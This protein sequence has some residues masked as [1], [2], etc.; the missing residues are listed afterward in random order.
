MNIGSFIRNGLTIHIN[1]DMCEVSGYLGTSFQHYLGKTIPKNKINALFINLS[2]FGFKFHTFYILEIYEII[3]SLLSKREYNLG[4]NVRGLSALLEEIDKHGWG[5]DKIEDREFNYD[6]IPDIF[7][8]KVL[9]HQMYALERYRIIS[10]RIGYRGMLYYV[11]PGG[12]KTMLSLF[13]AELVHSKKI[14]C[15]VPAAVLYKVWVY[16]ITE[17]VYIKPQEYW[18]AG[19]GEYKDQKF[20]LTSYEGLEKVL[21]LTKKLKGKDTTV[22][23]DESHNFADAKSIRTQ[24]LLKLVDEIDSDN[25]ILLSG[26]PL[27]SGNKEIP[28]LFSILDNRFRGEIRKAFETIYKSPG[29]ILGETLK[30]RFGEY[31]VIVR[32]EEFNTIPIT[33]NNIPIKLKKGDEFTLDNIKLVLRRYIQERG[34]YYANNMER[35]KEIYNNIYSMAKAKLIAQGRPTVDFTNYEN[36]FQNIL[37][38]Y[39]QNS[40]FFHGDVIKRVNEFENKVII[41]ILDTAD[42]E[43]FREAKTVVKYLALKL[44]GEAL[45]NVV[46]KYRILA[47]VE[48]AKTVNYKDIILSTNK[49]TIIFSNYVDVC[50]TVNTVVNKQGFK[51]ITVYGNTV[52]DLNRNVGIFTDK[53]NDINPLVTTF[54]SLSTGVP[55]IVANNILVIDLPFRMYTYEQAVAR[56]HRLGQDQPVTIN[57]LM[58]DTGDKPN[59]NSRNI[60]IIQYFKDEVEKITGQKVDLDIVVEN[61]GVVSKEAL[62]LLTTEVETGRLSIEDYSS[63]VITNW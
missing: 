32:K 4:V 39:K 25:N 44:Q 24:N 5:S 36:D 49:K 51:S 2:I 63:N 40:L 15:I 23:I 21:P 61:E 8:F 62:N 28:I 60:D 26:T 59:I 17:Q 14:I 20:I 58:L 45:A 19:D 13:T 16:S 41:P 30:I 38:Y 50:D 12:G 9:P 33:T 47:H 3:K 56:V 29:T 43:L 46:M 48:M 52:K 22:I 10:N 53:D 55:L 37:K 6:I 57:I 7:K 11:Q 54:K 34:L 42:K 31:S 27:K 35:F 18:I 1:Q